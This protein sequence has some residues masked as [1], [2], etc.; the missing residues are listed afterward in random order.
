METTY[1]GVLD[2][3]SGIK[4]IA[5]DGGAG[6]DSL[7]VDS[8]TPIPIPITYDGGAGT[9]A[10]T[11]TGGNATSDTYTPG[12]AL[13]TGTSQLTFG[14]VIQTVSFV[15]LA[16]V[17]DV[18]P[19]PLTVSATNGNDSIADRPP[20]SNADQGLISINDL[21][22]IEFG[23]KTSLTINTQNGTDAVSINNPTPQPGLVGGITVSGGDPAAGDTLTVSGTIAADTVNYRPTGAGSGSIAVATLPTVTFAGMASLTY[24]GAGGND[25]LTVTNPATT[26]GTD[27]TFTPGATADQGNVSFR[28][29]ASNGLGGILLTPLSYTQIDREGTL[30][31]ANSGQ[32]RQDNLTVNGSAAGDTFNISGNATG[33]GIGLVSASGLGAALNITASGVAGLTAQGVGSNDAF[34]VFAPI[35]FNVPD[36]LTT[37]LRLFG[38][39][40]G[41]SVAIA[42]DGSGQMTINPQFGDSLPQFS[43]DGLGNAGVRIGNITTAFV[44]A[45]TKAVL[46]S[47]TGNAGEAD[48]TPIGANEALVTFPGADTLYDVSNLGGSPVLFDELGRG[49]SFRLVGNP[50]DTAF[51]VSQAGDNTVVAAR[52]ATTGIDLLPASIDSADTASLLIQGHAGNDVLTVDSTA[53]PIAIPITYDGGTGRNSLTLTGGSATSDAYMPGPATGSGTIQTIIGGATQTINFLNLAPVVDTVAGPLTVNGTNGNDAI[54][55]RAPANSA[56]QGLV[57]VNDQETI[58]FGNKTSLT[59][60]TQNGTDAVSINNPTA[61]AG[62][63]G[64]IVVNGGD[65]AAGDGLT[66]SGTT[67]NDTINY[68]PTG[69]GAGAVTI[70]TLPKVTFTGIGSMAYDGAGGNDALTVTSPATSSLTSVTFTPGTTANQGSIALR[71]GTTTG[72]GGTLLPPLSYTNIDRD[73]SLTFASSVGHDTLF[74]NGAGAGDTF[75]IG[76]NAADNQILLERPGGVAGALNVMA[77]GESALVVQG[78]GSNDAFVIVAPLAFNIP[79][80]L[81][82]GVTVFGG[83]PNASAHI[84][85]DGSGQLTIVPQIADSLPQLTGDGLGNGGV[86]LGSI[87]S[88]SVTA[89]SQSV[90]FRGTGSAGE[91]DYTPIGADEGLV[92]LTGTE[93]LY[94]VSN[95]G[96]SPLLF[97]PIGPRSVLK[98]IATPDDTAF[99]VSQAGDST[100]VAV[101]DVTTGIDL[102]PASI[103]SADTSSLLVQGRSGNDVL[104][105]DSTAGPVAIPITYDGGTGTNSLTLTGGTATSDTYNPGPASGA[106]TS[107]ITIGGVAQ[108]VSFLN[109]APVLDTVA[110]PLTVDGTGGSNVINYTAG[111]SA[112]NG[113]VTVDS[114]ESIEFS[115]KTT[116]ALD[117]LGG[118]DTIIVNNPN[119]PTGLTALTADGGTGNNTLVVNASGQAVVS[120]DITA[121]TVAIPGALPSFGLG[122]TSIG[123]VQVIDARDAL[124]GVSAPPLAATQAVPLSDALVAAF[125]FSDPVPPSIFGSAG[126][127]VASIDWG[128]TTVSTAGTIVANGTNG[129]QVFGSHIYR[130]EGSYTIKVTVTDAGSTRRFTPSGGVPVT[131]VDSAGATTTPA[132]I[133]VVASVA[134]APLSAQGTVIN[135]LEGTPLTT[136]VAT[137]TDANPNTSVSDFTT[138]PGGVTIAW[139]DGSPLDTT[140]AVVTLIGT[141]PNGVIYSVTGTHDYLEEGA[142][143]VTVT[144]KDRGGSTTVASSNA[145]VADSPPAAGTQPK[146][147]INEG[148]TYTGPVAAFSEIWT[149]A[150]TSRT[151][152]EPLS[153]FTGLAPEIDWGDGTS[154]SLG[155]VVADPAFPANSG[156]FLVNGSHVYADSGVNIAAGVASKSFSVSV[157]VHDDGGANLAIANVAT[158][159]D[160][161]IHLTA[162][163]NPASD[164]GKFHNDA[165]TNVN[166]P[167][168]FGTSEP[169]SH[170]SLFAAATSGG[171][172]VLIGQTEAASDGSWNITSDRLADGSYQITASAVDQFGITTAGP[173]NVLPNTSQG[174]LVID[175]VG[176]RIVGLQFDRLSGE[177][178]VT[179]QDDRS[180]MLSQSLLDAANYTFNRRHLRLPGT[181]IVTSLTQSGGATPTSP[182]TVAVQ[183]NHGKPLRGGFF[184]ITV[185]AASVLRRSGVQDLAGN[186]LDGEFYGAGTASGNGVPGGDFVANLTA[187]HNTVKPPQTIIGFPHPNDPTGHFAKSKRTGARTSGP[188]GH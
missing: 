183:I 57:S 9:N 62:L 140:T 170:I 49:N 15:N 113:L 176:P 101:R 156:H 130:S 76:G 99:N 159:S 22:T 61:Q 133:T 102:L 25:V 145:V 6:S 187:I 95:L 40:P 29:E 118:D 171:A 60:N 146:I 23:K 42:G 64:G 103:V 181:F 148:A 73:G 63:T 137:F 125:H 180:G 89:G 54:A 157:T 5:V 56:N 77:A 80:V 53:A 84:V 127:F 144:I 37:G 164:S 129:F 172:P 66:V 69:P 100:V 71:Q 3:A 93:T 20:A 143:P 134:S 105:V 142:F 19:G 115:N 152:V 26:N 182:Q 154:P 12:P 114:S 120:T 83:G 50:G 169:F 92:A 135:A 74:Y 147:A 185:H 166:Q 11:L 1:S 184:S 55:Y 186:A 126:D 175:T 128:D 8:T 4:G 179:F 106:G 65:P 88:A 86:S 7:T 123:Q 58:E 51:N 110:G 10:L 97:D 174:P 59:I 98:V 87:A 131:I 138:P 21:E 150:A 38:G 124:T 153:D 136:T 178:S 13:G 41:A 46:F 91:A 141:T 139:G 81:N 96:G 109:L 27:M 90:L 94:D 117:G 2:P 149:D 35:A 121:T 122:Y 14:A 47:G 17:T 132:P 158:V 33:D 108:T 43:G 52:D 70:A 85:G 173:I 72:A 75:T 168:F 48:D 31:F 18:V 104:T 79:D 112:A 24:N 167:N 67:G 107:Q 28:E 36:A 32:T 39:G 45:A 160:V 44:N 177:V 163:L 82:T 151:N 162:Q 119:T 116:L 161:A 34:V 165:I 78:V 68:L 16:P 155:S 111:S 188:R 30:V